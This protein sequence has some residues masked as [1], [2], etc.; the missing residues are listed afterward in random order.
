MKKII[1]ILVIV[2]VGIFLLIQLFPYGHNHGNPPV[3]NPYAWKNPQ[4]EEIA[5]RACYD[6]HSNESVWPWYSNI[7][8]ISWMIQNHVDEGRQRL[9]FSES[10]GEMDDIPGEVMEGGM[11]PSSYLLMHSSARL[12]DQEKQTLSS[13]FGGADDGGESGESGENE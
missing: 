4:A 10:T 11:P 3:T 5:R 9:N 12:S 13:E 6:C 2:V 1:G 8:P 7:A